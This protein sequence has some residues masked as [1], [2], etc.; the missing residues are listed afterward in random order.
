MRLIEQAEQ[1]RP[2]EELKHLPGELRGIYVLYRYRR[3]RYRRRSDKYD[4]LYVGMARSDGRRGIRGRLAKHGR[5]KKLWTHFS[6]FAVW[7]NISDED[8]IQLEGLFRHIYSRD[9]T[10]NKLN[11]Q[12]GFKQM[13]HLPHIIT[14]ES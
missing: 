8:V 13:K 11:L 10:A 2:K 6:A 7:P 12:R 4:V 9:S 3:H 14:G 5:K 1:F